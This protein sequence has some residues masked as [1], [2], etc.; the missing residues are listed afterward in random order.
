M[1]GRNRRGNRSRAAH[2][3]TRRLENPT[4][5][6]HSHTSRNERKKPNTPGHAHGAVCTNTAG[7]VLPASYSEP[8]PAP[9]TR[10]H[11]SKKQRHP[12]MR[13]GK[14]HS[15]RTPTHSPWQ[16]DS[17]TLPPNN[18]QL[19]TLHS[20]SSTSV[21]LFPPSLPPLC[22]LFLSFSSFSFPPHVV[23][24]GLFFLPH[25]AL[26]HNHFSKPPLMCSSG[27]PHSLVFVSF[28]RFFTL[29]DLAKNSTTFLSLPARPF[30]PLLPDFYLSLFLEHSAL[31]RVTVTR[32]KGEKLE[33]LERRGES[34][35][36]Q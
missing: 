33:K 28:T 24:P 27:T 20:T 26:P 36:E 19:T 23:P 29:T 32:R 7:T 21:S 6:M 3:C 34:G 9:F 31:R 4:T 12:P 30:F 22:F 8:F 10:A 1:A 35:Q 15:A 17:T 14:K 18:T 16:L 25:G 5:D 2:S 11:L 13:P